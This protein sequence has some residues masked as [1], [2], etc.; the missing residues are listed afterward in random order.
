MRPPYL[1]PYLCECCGAALPTGEDGLALGHPVTDEELGLVVYARA[2]G[3]RPVRLRD[4]SAVAAEALCDR[5]TAAR[6]LAGRRVAPL[7]AARLARACRQLQIPI[8]KEEPDAL[9]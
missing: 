4:V 2:R 1:T 9:S 7:T 5:R 3:F 8:P 6:F